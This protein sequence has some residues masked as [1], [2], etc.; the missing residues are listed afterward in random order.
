MT[1][2]ETIRIAGVVRQS[3][4]DGPGLRLVVFTQ[5]C[6]H[7]CPGCQNPETHD[8]AGGYDCAVPSILAELDKNPLLKGLTISGGE[9]FC[10]AG[11]LLALA[12]AV[13]ARGKDIWCYTGYTFEE[14]QRSADTAARSLL[15]LL[16]VL[17]DGRFELQQKDLTLRFRGSGNQR[18]LD[19]PRSLAAG[20]AVA[21][22]GF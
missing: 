18:V 17:V 5:G 19:V 3:I 9:P 16:D 21:L 13:R 22:A 8:F 12:E 14:L 7:A 11:E 20:A 2:G 15:A 1:G 4:V 6:P 10:R